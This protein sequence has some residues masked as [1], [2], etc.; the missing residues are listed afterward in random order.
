MFPET[1]S[2]MKKMHGD[3]AHQELDHTIGLQSEG[4]GLSAID[5]LQEEVSILSHPSYILD[6]L[7]KK[8]L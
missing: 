6:E 7:Q 1:I 2:R 5:P 4:D 8:Q 3:N